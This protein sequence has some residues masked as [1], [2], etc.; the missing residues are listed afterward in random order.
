LL[1]RWAKVKIIKAS[2]DPSKVGLSMRRMAA[3]DPLRESPDRYLYTRNW[4]ISGMESWGP[5]DNG[6]G[7]PAKEIK[8]SIDTFYRVPVSVDHEAWRGVGLVVDSQWIPM[9]NQLKDV[10]VRT[11]VLWKD[12]PYE[13]ERIYANKSDTQA[14]RAVLETLGVAHESNVDFQKLAEEYPYDFVMNI[15]ALDKESLENDTP[16]LVDAMLNGEVTD[17][18]MGCYVKSAECSVCG[19][20]VEDEADLCEHITQYKGAK[21]MKFA[22]TEEPVDVY[23]VNRG[24]V[25]FEDSIILPN[26]FG[27]QAGGEGADPNAKLEVV[28]RA[29]SDLSKY[30]IRRSIKDGKVVSEWATEIPSN[31]YTIGGK[32]DIVQEAEDNVDSKTPL[33]VGGKEEDE[34]HE[35]KVKE[36]KEEKGDSLPNINRVPEASVQKN[37]SSTE[38]ID[39]IVSLVEQGI[40]VEEAIQRAE[41]EFGTSVDRGD[42]YMQYSGSKEET[43]MAK[44]T[45]KKKIAA[46][47][48][49]LRKAEHEDVKVELVAELDEAL[50]AAED[51]DDEETKPAPPEKKDDDKDEK[52]SKLV[53]KNE[54]DESDEEKVPVPTPDSREDDEEEEEVEE[55]ESRLEKARRRAKIRAKLRRLR[56][57]R[58]SNFK[59][60]AEDDEEDEEESDEEEDDEKE[61]STKR[62]ERLE[63]AKRKLR[64]RQVSPRS[65]LRSRVRTK[66]K[67]TLRNQSELNAKITAMKN[68]LAHRIAL[69]MVAKGMISTAG[70]EKKFEELMDKSTME[71]KGMDEMVDMIEGKPA[72]NPAER[73]TSRTRRTK[74]SRL[75]RRRAETKTLRENRISSARKNIRSS[76]KTRLPRQA[77]RGIENTS[78]LD[79]GTMF[80]DI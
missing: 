49:L 76:N 23:E 69:K 20:I 8:N 25:F 27:G 61:A 60:R 10:G 17:T 1:I 21:G 13:L 35:E 48:N 19:N 63:M 54:E 11:S 74:A 53:L 58:R 67:K 71:L 38:L 29:V 18:S 15:F 75:P 78:L 44:S 33:D 59:S 62:K 3:Y 77:G 28:G 43:I 36:I 40:P 26:T 5:N 65:K 37:A 12:L 72:R 14:K 31:P 73:R 51:E 56:K 7:F 39:F 6:D 66:A 32:P 52:E 80:E 22:G 79:R 9:Q 30:A 57:Q 16:G 24:L 68:A 46:L 4:S 42:F 47:R 41:T 34:I 55:K 2:L 70:S 64:S 50:L 45:R